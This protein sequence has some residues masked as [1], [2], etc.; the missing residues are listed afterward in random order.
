MKVKKKPSKG[1]L[2][3]KGKSLNTVQCDNRSCKPIEIP[4]DDEV[5]ALNALR[6][7]KD[8]VRSLKNII[9]EKANNGHS[10]EGKEKVESELLEL[11]TLWKEWDKKREFAA[12][13]RMIALGHIKPDS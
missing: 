10:R 6:E 2:E 4:T 5:K 9:I 8:R 13:E 7:I 12:K 1:D 11:K 3:M